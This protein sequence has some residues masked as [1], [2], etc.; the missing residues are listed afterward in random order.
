MRE[1]LGKAKTV[2]ERD[3]TYEKKL[4]HYNTQSLL[5]RPLHPQ[6]Y[7]HNPGFLRFLNE[8][9]RAFKSYAQFPKADLEERGVLCRQIAERIWNPDDLLRETG[10]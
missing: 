10:A 4:A 5:A 6:C 9:G 3:L 7:E 8:S 1:I 2:R